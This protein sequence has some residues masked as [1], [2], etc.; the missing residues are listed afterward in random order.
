MIINVT[1][2]SLRDPKDWILDYLLCTFYQKYRLSVQIRH[3]N[4]P[5][6][7]QFAFYERLPGIYFIKHIINKKII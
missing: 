3:Y 6:L 2:R 1:V 5:T 7:R 4:I